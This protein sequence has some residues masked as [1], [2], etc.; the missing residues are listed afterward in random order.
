MLIVGAERVSREGLLVDWS[1]LGGG[2]KEKR[3]L[4]ERCCSLNG[5]KYPQ[6]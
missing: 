1:N 3:S 2:W 5:R 6:R 4:S